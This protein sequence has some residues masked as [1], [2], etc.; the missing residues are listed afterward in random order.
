MVACK[1]IVLESCLL[2][3]VAEVDDV[4]EPEKTSSLMVA[5][6]EGFRT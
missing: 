5:A 1:S 2:D 3:S 4:R 6:G